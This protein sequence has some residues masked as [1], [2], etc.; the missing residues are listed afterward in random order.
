MFSCAFVR[1]SGSI[2]P[3]HLQADLQDAEGELD[4]ADMGVDITDV[5]APEVPAVAAGSPEKVKKK[6]KKPED[7]A[8]ASGSKDAAAPDEVLSLAKSLALHLWPHTL[9][10]MCLYL[11]CHHCNILS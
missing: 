5:P 8:G 3:F 2:G 11:L 6:R 9:V 4:E 1:G 7:A 10:C